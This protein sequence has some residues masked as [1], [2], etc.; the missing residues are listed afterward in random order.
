MYFE[1]AQALADETLRQTGPQ[2]DAN[3]VAASMFRRL[4]V[5]SPDERELEAIVNFYQSHQD[6][7]KAWAL[8]ARALINTDEAITTP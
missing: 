8:V 1:I 5:R 7:P 2:A 6:D 3:H 4:L